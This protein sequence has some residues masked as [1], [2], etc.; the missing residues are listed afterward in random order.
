M[1][2]E[3]YTFRLPKGLGWTFLGVV[4]SRGKPV[5]QEHPDEA[6]PD[7][8]AAR[9]AMVQWGDRT[10]EAIRQATRDL[11]GSYSEE[12]TEGMVEGVILHRAPGDVH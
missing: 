1:Q 2:V 8:E 7:E 9:K 10:M 6:Y 11:G 4:K 5:H 12:R 3:A